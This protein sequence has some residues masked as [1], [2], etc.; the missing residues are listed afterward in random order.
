MPTL[1]K[2]ARFLVLSAIALMVLVIVPPFNDSTNI[3]KYSVLFFIA[4]LGVSILSIPKFGLFEKKNWLSWFPPLLFLSTMLAIA[5]IT[6]QKYPAFFG[7]YGRN[8]GWFQYFGLTVLFLLTAFSF[9]FVTLSKFFNLLAILGLIV[10]V[11]G[12]FQYHDIDFIN[13]TTPG[14]PIIATL[15]NPNFASAFMG[16]AAVTVVWKISEIKV[17]WKK[18]ILA[19]VLIFQTYVIY[20]SGSSQGLFILLIGALTFVGI[21]YFTSSKKIGFSYFSLFGLASFVGL[22]GLF[23]IGPL[24]KFVY[25]ESTTY[26]GDYYRAAW[27]MFKSH[28]FS[29]V[30]IERFGEYYRMYRDADA[31]TRLGPRFVTNYAHNAFLQLMATGG[32]ILF[33]AFLVMIVV[34]AIA[35]V[36]GLRSFKGSEKA[37]FGALVSMWFAFQIQA[38]ISIDQITIAALG[39]VLAGAVIALGFNSKLIAE[40]AFQPNT[41]SKKKR[42]AMSNS[43]LVA[44]GLTLVLLVASFVWL[45]PIWKADYTIK[46]ARLLQGDAGD[47]NFLAEKKNLA[48]KA[49]KSAPN[50][51]R[52]KLL[53]SVV[54]SSVKDLDLARQQLRDAYVL[55]PRSYDSVVMAAQVYEMAG[56][57]SEA[58][59]TRIAASKMDPNDTDNWLQLGKDLAQVRDF[60][61]IDKLIELVKPLES[62]STIAE[63][64]RKL[65]PAVPTS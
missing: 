16:F 40:K 36:K 63:D 60:K 58:I 55:D 27:G 32:V 53:A 13:Y 52:Y 7:S 37:A 65:L 38:Q 34:I 57:T 59:K 22:L 48:L 6:D 49:V 15:G 64:L 29:G 4:A 5:L 43:T 3:P 10:T 51:I 23:Q 2:R 25:Q 14:N 41:Y 47:F 12:F 30:G 54:L 11:Y 62:K 61:A 33:L 42:G 26:R 46:Q 44:G 56:L 21:K 8:N 1:Q 31:A 28:P 18:S 19:L 17:L 39:W 20:V 45:A 35:A 9:N 24:T 50:E